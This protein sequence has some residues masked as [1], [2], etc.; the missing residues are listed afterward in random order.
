MG[1]LSIVHW[2]IILLVV[3]LLFGGSRLSNVMGE[4]AKGI[5]AFRAGMREDDPP[6]ASSAPMG[7]VQS[8][9]PIAPA[10]TNVGQTVSNDRKVG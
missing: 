2:M 5:K 4:A 6:Q 10:P 1:S 9:Q 7:Q 3:L 8:Q